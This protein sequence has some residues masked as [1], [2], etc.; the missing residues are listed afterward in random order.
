MRV[1]NCNLLKLLALL[2]GPSFFSASGSHCKSLC[3]NMSRHNH[4]WMG[5]WF[6]HPLLAIAANQPYT[7]TVM[8]HMGL[9]QHL[10]PTKIPS[11][12]MK[13]SYHHFTMWFLKIV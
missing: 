5:W 10:E 9:S 8:I 3:P 13:S 11:R 4:V 12:F 6:S 7:L 1:S 2:W